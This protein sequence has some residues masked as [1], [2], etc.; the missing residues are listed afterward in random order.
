MVV[1][2]YV[3]MTMVARRRMISWREGLGE[4]QDAH[5]IVF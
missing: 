4:Y 5:S 1:G 2:V 3:G